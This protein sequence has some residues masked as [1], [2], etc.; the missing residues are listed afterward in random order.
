MQRS[1]PKVP[2]S[3]SIRIS[4]KLQE[5]VCRPAMQNFD[6]CKQIQLLLC[7]PSPRCCCRVSKRI[8]RRPLS[9]SDSLNDVFKRI[10]LV[11]SH[12]PMK[13]SS[14]L[15]LA[16]T[17][18]NAYVTVH[19]RF[20]E[21]SVW[22]WDCGNANSKEICMHTW[23]SKSDLQSD[24][25]ECVAARTRLKKRFAC[26]HHGQYPIRLAV[27]MCGCENA[28]WQVI[29]INTRVWK[30]DLKKWIIERM[31]AKERPG[32]WYL[33]QNEYES[34]MRKLIDVITIQIGLLEPRKNFCGHH[35]HVLIGITSSI[36]FF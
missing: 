34:T 6:V 24:P 7:N 23:L 22:I 11:Q 3:L 33:R 15:P 29:R 32:K 14:T 36:M 5:D 4:P 26:I 21:W 16:V 28:M 18:S 30:Y 20:K 13:D 12:H 19:V 35:S 8:S 31:T 2:V 10:S 27:W 17:H 25:F 1:L 9:N